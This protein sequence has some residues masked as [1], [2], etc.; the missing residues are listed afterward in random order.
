M[1]EELSISHEAAENDFTERLKQQS[2]FMLIFLFLKK[3]TIQI[4]F[5]PTPP[6]PSPACGASSCC[7]CPPTLCSCNSEEPLRAASC[8]RS[9]SPAE[10]T[11]KGRLIPRLSSG[12]YILL[13]SVFATV[14]PLFCCVVTTSSGTVEAFLL[15]SGHMKKLSPDVPELLSFPKTHWQNVTAASLKGYLK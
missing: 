15:A 3:N 13:K 6:S 11:K 2:K 14:F 4:S 9:Q 12:C 1:D 10:E 8:C 7:C 5:S